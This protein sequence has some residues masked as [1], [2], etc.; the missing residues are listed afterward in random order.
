MTSPFDR[1]TKLRWRRRFRRSKKQVEQLG[2]Q[3]EQHLEHNV[4]RRLEH[5]ASVRRFVVSWTALLLIII[6]GV[7]YQTTAL[8]QYYQSKKPIPGGVYTEG[9]LGTFTDANPIYATSSVDTSVSRLLFASLLKYNEKAELV[10]DLAETWGVDEK[11]TTYTVKLRPGVAWHDGVPLTA[12]DVAFT[13]QTIQNPDAKSPLLAS[14]Q[15]IKIAATDAR[16]V[17]FVLPNALVAFPHSL[18][19]GIIPKHLLDSIPV[20]QLRSIPFNTEKPVGSGPFKLD[21]LEVSG[22]TPETRQEQIAL[23]PNTHYHAG[24]PKLQRFTVKTFISAKSM[25]QSFLDQELTSV[26]GVESASDQMRANEDLVEYSTTLN[27]QVGA[28]FKVSN[29][30]LSDQKVR[31]ALV[32]SV[33]QASLIRS[34]GYPVV[35]TK[36][37]FL[38]SQFSYNK[39]S[40]QLRYNPGDAAKLL[41][42][43]GWKLGNE[44][45]RYKDKKAL[46]FQFYA[47]NTGEYTAVA[48]ELESYWRKIG[49]NVTLLLQ[50]DIELH[51]TVADHTYDV[52]LYGITVG[53]DPDVFAYWH[54]SQASTFSASRLNFSEYKSSVADKALEAG[55]LRSDQALRSVKYKPFL[56]AWRSDAPA[57][58]L[59]QPRYVYLANQKVYGY[60]MKTMNDPVDRYTNVQNW[61]IRTAKTTNN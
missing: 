60:S 41:D 8:A 17:T 39:D 5:F 25:E 43:A 24:A 29:P 52:L 30:V 37:P 18:V 51:K 49:V 40:T 28:F 20:S 16:T 34:L 61:M 44:G 12:A 1:T 36:S 46:S 57:L 47:P 33:D 54:S 4:L 35:I 59:Y 55:R 48:K 6:A 42:E 23:V 31:Q 21:A 38:K 7:V 50:P 45:I 11:G 26:S 32:Q 22:D 56:E 58:M 2:E 27:S 3:A 9:I 15:G 10:N 19:T 13:Y 53:S 14:W